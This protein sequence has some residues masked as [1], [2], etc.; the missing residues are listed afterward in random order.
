MYEKK[1]REV[2]FPAL[3]KMAKKMNLSDIKFQDDNAK[4]HTKAWEKLGLAE[5]AEKITKGVRI[6]RQHQSARSPDLNVCD[7]Y[8]WGVLQAGVN[9]RRPKTIDELWAAIQA[10]WEEDLTADKLECAFRLLDPV[11]ACIY[12]NNVNRGNAFRLPHTGIR[13]QMREDGWNI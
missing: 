12:N 11:M 7:L 10:S 13:E 9:K 2:A 8:I 6:N 3:R 4:P 1:L 5:V